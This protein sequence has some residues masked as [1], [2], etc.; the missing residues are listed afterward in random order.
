MKLSMVHFQVDFAKSR[1]KCTHSVHLLKKG[2]MI[3]DLRRQP[4]IFRPAVFVN[5]CEINIHA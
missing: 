4:M 5:I 1:W 3:T 2:R